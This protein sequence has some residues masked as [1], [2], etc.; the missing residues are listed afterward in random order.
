MRTHAVA[1]QA[2]AKAKTGNGDDDPTLADEV[3]A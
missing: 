2:S 1:A 3:A